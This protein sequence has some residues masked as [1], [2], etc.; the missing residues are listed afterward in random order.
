M[1]I[2]RLEVNEHCQSVEDQPD[3]FAIHL[4]I[5]QDAMQGDNLPYTYELQMIGFIQVHPDFP[6]ENLQKII[7][8]NGPS[9]LFGAAR[10]ILRDATGRGPY[11][12][13][14]IPSTSFIK[15]KGTET[16]KPLKPPGATSRSK[17]AR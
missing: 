9:M 11:G 10:E 6:K 7:E 17:K 1:N 2:D 8:T 3:R 13:I 14:L 12:P 15:S 5:K 16:P 4:L